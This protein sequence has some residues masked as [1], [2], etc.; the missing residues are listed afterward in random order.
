MRAVAGCQVQEKQDFYGAVP[1]EPT[2]GGATVTA[3]PNGLTSSGKDASPKKVKLQKTIKKSPHVSETSL[4]GRISTATWFENV[5]L[6]I[7]A[8]N[9]TWI[10]VDI[11]WN[12]AEYSFPGPVFFKVGES[13]FC[14]LFTLE[15]VVRILAYNKKYRF[16]TDPSMWKWNL[17][18]FVLVCVMVFETWVLAYI[19]QMK[20]DSLS[21]FSILRLARLLRLS[22]LFRLVPELG[23]MATSLL[24]AVRSVS[25]T[26]VLAIGVMYVFAILLTQWVKSYGSSGLCVGATEDDEGVCLQGY[27]GTIFL[28][29]L[30]LTQILVFDDTFMIIRPV[31]AE[32]FDMGSVLIVYIMLVSYTVLNMLIGVICEIV[33]N[34][35]TKEKKKVLRQHIMDVF[36]QMD[37]DNSGV[38]SKD[39]FNN[40]HAVDILR[41]LGIDSSLL[42]NAFDLLDRNNDGSLE[43][44]EFIDMIFTLLESPKAEDLLTMHSRIEN[45]AKSAGLDVACLAV[46]KKDKLK[47][48]SLRGAGFKESPKSAEQ[49]KVNTAEE[50][51]VAVNDP[52]AG[53]IMDRFADALQR[54]RHLQCA[55]AS[56]RSRRHTAAAGDGD[57]PA[58]RVGLPLNVRTSTVSEAE[59][60]EALNLLPLQLEGLCTK[61]QALP[62]PDGD[63]GISFAIADA[64]QRIKDASK[65]V[66]SMP[67][68]PPPDRLCEWRADVKE[69]GRSPGSATSAGSPGSLS[70]SLYIWPL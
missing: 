3:A 21:V 11:D 32:R 29:F 31:F 46:L 47:Y 1:A 17:F 39:E 42:L 27:F 50:R 66:E 35:T 43:R 8:G 6:V 2:N 15:L 70:S 34:T 63:E 16:F 44:K 36:G 30:S 26:C 59:R 65:Y 68:T 10:G 20:L 54:L 22:R 24:A 7:I 28:S 56:A 51:N 18:D 25:S 13:V 38:L 4:C 58:T 52:Q 61:L 60:T 41:K 23:M 40:Q 45:C 37:V 62:L 33:S 5:A 69:A 53:R 12:R 49:E 19:M 57:A 55:I 48:A 14:S 67:P 64:L 9:A